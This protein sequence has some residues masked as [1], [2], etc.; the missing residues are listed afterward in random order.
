M[1]KRIYRLN[2]EW[3]QEVIVPSSPLEIDVVRQ[4]I[5][6]DRFVFDDEMPGQLRGL[7]IEQGGRL[8]YDAPWSDKL[9]MHYIVG[10]HLGGYAFELS[11]SFYSAQTCKSIGSLQLGC[12]LTPSSVPHDVQGAFNKFYWR[13]TRS[14]FLLP[15]WFV[16]SD[17]EPSADL[18]TKSHEKAA[19]TLLAFEDLH[20][21]TRE[22]R[23]ALPHVVLVEP[24]KAV[25]GR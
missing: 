23:D 2:N 14:T 24:E 19:W 13:E 12:A 15:R 11:V 10:K 21:T 18:Q 9:V 20:P 5:V 6:P 17:R 4:V 22:Y 3:L 1:E 8:F 25:H 7:A 16:L